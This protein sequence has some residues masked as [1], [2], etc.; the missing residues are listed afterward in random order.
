MDQYEFEAGETFEFLLFFASRVQCERRGVGN[1]LHAN[2]FVVRASVE[3]WRG[4]KVGE[5]VGGGE[6]R[7]GGGG[8]GEGGEVREVFGILELDME[9]VGWSIGGC[10]RGSRHCDRSGLLSVMERGRR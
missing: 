9:E 2:L 6:R 10:G 7:S 3:K 4:G 1:V 8:W 5:D